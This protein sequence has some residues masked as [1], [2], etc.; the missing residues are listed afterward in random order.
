[1]LKEIEDADGEIV[2]FTMRCTRSW[3]QAAAPTAPWTP[4]TC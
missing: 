2:T 4:A 1:M 3:A